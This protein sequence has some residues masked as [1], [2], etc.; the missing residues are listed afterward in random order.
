M[1]NQVPVHSDMPW[2][3][4]IAQTRAIAMTILRE[5]LRLLGAI[6]PANVTDGLQLL[7]IAH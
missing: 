2:K 6:K 4:L 7:Q 1:D 5:T 3:C